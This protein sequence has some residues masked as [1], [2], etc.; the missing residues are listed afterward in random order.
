MEARW[1]ELGAVSH[2][3]E[4]GSAEAANPEAFHLPIN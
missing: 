3:L 4:Q 1:I 2:K